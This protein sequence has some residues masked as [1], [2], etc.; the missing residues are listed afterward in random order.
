[1]CDLWVP[2]GQRWERPLGLFHSNALTSRYTDGRWEA[3]INKINVSQVRLGES[4]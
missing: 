1:M 4:G 2:T 3:T